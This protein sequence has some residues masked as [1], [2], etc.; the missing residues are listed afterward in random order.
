[1]KIFLLFFSLFVLNNFG[2]ISPAEKILSNFSNSPISS[3]DII[4]NDSE[5][6]LAWAKAHDTNHSDTLFFAKTT[7]L[8][9]SYSIFNSITIPNRKFATKSK[10]KFIKTS[11]ALYLFFL[12]TLSTS[13]QN[14][15]T[16]IKSIDNGVTWSEAKTFDNFFAMNPKSF[17]AVIPNQ[18]LIHLVYQSNSNRLYHIASVD[19]GLTWGTN[20]AINS[21]LTVSASS[22]ELIIT[23][24]NLRVYSLLA[25]DADQLNLI[26]MISTDNGNS[27][28]EVKVIGTVLSPFLGSSGISV[29]SLDA[30]QLGNEISFVFTY[31][32]ELNIAGFTYNYSTGIMSDI[33]HLSSYAGKNYNA[34]LVNYQNQ[35]HFAWITDREFYSAIEDGN[36]SI[37]IDYFD[38]PYD[39]TTYPVITDPNLVGVLVLNQNIKCY[40]R[41][42]DDNLKEVYT[43]WN[44]VIYPMNDDGTYPDE[45]ANDEIFSTEFNILD[46]T[47]EFKI[48]AVDENGNLSLNDFGSIAALTGKET[49]LIDKGRF[50][51]PISYDGV[52][53][54]V[55]IDSEW[56]GGLY[57]DE[58]AIFSSGFYL[59]GYT[60]GTLWANGVLSASRIQ[61]YL[62]GKAFGQPDDDRYRIYL[63]DESFPDFG[64]SWQEWKAAVDLGAKFYD[65]DNDGIYNPIDK[66]NNGKWDADEDKPDIIGQRSYWY[67]INDGVPKEQ[68]R[69]NVD[70]QGIEIRTTFFVS[71]NGIS[72]AF[73]NTIFVRYE[74]ENTGL[75]SNKLED[76]YFT[77]AQDPDIGDY[78]ND[79][80]GTS[81]NYASGFCYDKGIDNEYG[82]NS[83]TV[84][85]SIIEGP[86]NYWKGKSFQDNNNNNIFDQGIDTPLDTAFVRNGQLL[87]ESSF[88][89]ALNQS[90]HSVSQYMSSHPT[91]GDPD[92]VAELRNYQ[93]GGRG[94]NADSLYISNWSFG[95][96]AS[97]GADSNLHPTKFMYWG[98]PE[99]QTGWLNTVPIDQRIMVTTGPFDL[100]VGKPKTIL[101]AYVIARGT[102]SLNSVTLAKEY[103]Q[104]LKQSYENNF[105]DIPV[106]VKT[107]N[108]NI[109]NK[110]ELSQNYPNPFNP[111]TSIEYTVMSNEKV[112]LRVYDILGREVVELINKTQ[113]PG[114]YKVQFDA[115]NLSS[116]VYFYRIKTSSGFVLTKKL[117]LLK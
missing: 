82:D 70:P 75:V 117:M 3:F 77:I 7:D 98:D 5:L 62:P 67:V 111:S 18:N 6:V 24:N 23:D 102:T 27:W 66:N 19:D 74:I 63:V 84:F 45:Y 109:P 61:D 32:D 46:L 28:S 64:V 37:W 17:D 47:N 116:G 71:S 92:K 80:I 68:R 104:E 30:L 73:D 96:G 113:S 107:V 100:E 59:S 53:A 72:E 105:A 57:D 36:S 87:G 40:V 12:S 10:I 83:P 93:L 86:L 60:N 43:K 20:L 34:Q 22:I 81:V 49:T 58:V 88:P 97:L 25:D 114:K 21:N 9:N 13:S 41:V 56:K 26:E 50:K 108:Q 85:L 44:D 101:G 76:M 106:S 110:Y 38:N 39:I 16:F 95:N 33:R 1:M 2:Q 65:G 8:G 69:F 91:H 89:G 14:R 52:I 4:S 31:S 15:I 90:L 29:K 112:E 51:L 94:K 55:R 54:D 78:G 99:T 35:I 42:V 48:Y 11:D 79:L 103:L 115:S